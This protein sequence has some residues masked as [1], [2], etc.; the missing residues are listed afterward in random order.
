MPGRQAKK[1]PRYAQVAAD[2]R[3]AILRGDFGPDEQIPTEAELCARYGVSRFT[4]RE[5]LRQLQNEKLIRRRRGSGTVVE[6]NG[7]DSLRQSLSDVKELLQYAAGSTFDFE[8]KGLVTLSAKEARD[9]CVAAGERWFLFSGIR[10]MAGHHRP[11]ALTEAYVHQDFADIVPKLK[12]GA[13]TI[14]QQLERLSG[15]HVAR[16]TQDIQ[17]IGAGAKEAAMLG[18]PR[19]SPCLRILRCYSDAAGKLVEMS[20]SVHPG[21][22]FTYSMHIDA[23]A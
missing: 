19:R 1:A 4:V 16:V 10:T 21:D 2:L 6:A 5:A 20:A 18:V 13:A 17:A 15:R 9:L 3:G 8:P 23:D 11:I 12:P 7:G 22:L 14:F